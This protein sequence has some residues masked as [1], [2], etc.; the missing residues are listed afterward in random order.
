MA[1]VGEV[2]GPKVAAIAEM[3]TADWVQRTTERDWR[4]AADVADEMLEAEIDP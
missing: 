2:A 1:V 4:N 3:N